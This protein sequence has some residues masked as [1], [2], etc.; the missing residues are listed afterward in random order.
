MFY[1][2]CMPEPILHK[3]RCVWIGVEFFGVTEYPSRTRAPFRAREV[4]PEEGMRSQYA[5]V[6]RA[7]LSTDDE[8]DD[9]NDG[10]GDDNKE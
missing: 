1:L 9:D 4:F 3:F 7:K 2:A 8:D 5:W 10:G 6:P